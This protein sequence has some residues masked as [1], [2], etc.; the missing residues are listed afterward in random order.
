[1]KNLFSAIIAL[2]GLSACQAS[3][4]YE[5]SMNFDQANVQP[6]LE[7]LNANLG[8]SL[9]T[10]ALSEFVANTSVEHEQFQTISLQYQGKSVKLEFRVFK[11]DIDAPDLYFFSESQPL[12]SGINTE[13][14]AFVQDLGL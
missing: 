7:R 4:R 14:A 2:V 1:M 10:I 6:F 5:A 13:L 8:V 9:D 12:I 3:D 11:D